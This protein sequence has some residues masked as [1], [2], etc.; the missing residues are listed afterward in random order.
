MSHSLAQLI[1][2]KSEITSFLG[3]RLTAEWWKKWDRTGQAISSLLA[4]LKSHMK[5]PESCNWNNKFWF[6]MP[7]NNSAA[8]IS[9]NYKI[10]LRKFL[11]PSLT[12]A[13]KSCWKKEHIL[14]I[15]DHFYFWRRCNWRIRL[16]ACWIIINVSSCWIYHL[17]K[18]KSTLCERGRS[19]AT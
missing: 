10:L 8:K 7:C 16:N 13:Y 17:T 14:G 5:N 3:Q 2:N 15:I 4:R 9:L 18:R 6:R 1:R 11:L 19:K 12:K